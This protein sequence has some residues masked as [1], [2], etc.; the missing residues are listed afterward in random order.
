M[1]ITSEILLPL[2]FT[3]GILTWV[4]DETPCDALVLAFSWHSGRDWFYAGWFS[5]R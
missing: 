3:L 2:F 1:P 4:L 5:S